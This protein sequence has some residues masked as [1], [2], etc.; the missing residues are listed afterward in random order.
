[1]IATIPDE[2]L[3]VE[4]PPM[5]DW[6]ESFIAMKMDVLIRFGKWQ[7]IIDEPLPDDPALYSV[8]TTMTHYAKAL[9][10]AALG[11]VEAAEEEKQ[12]FIDAHCAR[13]T[14]RL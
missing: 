2:L 12:G 11:N 7:A 1:M 5:A 8:T 13:D 9:A 3:R 10:H 6:L 14:H 4:E